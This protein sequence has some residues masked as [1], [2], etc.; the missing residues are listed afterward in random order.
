LRNRSEILTKRAAHAAFFV[1]Y[2]E[3]LQKFLAE[4][5]FCFANTIFSAENLQM[6][7]FFCIF[8]PNFP[9]TN[10]KTTIFYYSTCAA[11]AIGNGTGRPAERWRAVGGAKKFYDYYGSPHNKCQEPI[12]ERHVLGLRDIGILR[13]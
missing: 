10:E 8:V 11:N 3:I 7:D 1:H 5:S 9:Q 2:S 13:G 12:Q 4:I 6:S